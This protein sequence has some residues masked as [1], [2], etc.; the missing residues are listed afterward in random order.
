M[1]K[2]AAEKT[3]LILTEI[4]LYY[5]TKELTRKNET[6]LELQECYRQQECVIR[7]IFNK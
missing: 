6:N 4:R 7:N 3:N 5:A 1:N 2:N